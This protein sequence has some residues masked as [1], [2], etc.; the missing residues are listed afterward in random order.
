[1]NI[2]LSSSYNLHQQYNYYENMQNTLTRYIYIY[3]TSCFLMI[4][5]DS[6]DLSCSVFFKSMIKNLEEGMAKS[7]RSCLI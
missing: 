4:P 6:L 2:V 3:I 1:M 7:F 5:L